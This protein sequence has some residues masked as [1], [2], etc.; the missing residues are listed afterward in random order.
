MAIQYDRLQ[1]KMIITGSDIQNLPAMLSKLRRVTA[2]FSLRLETET[3]THSTR[4]NYSA[5]NEEDRITWDDRAIYYYCVG[6]EHSPVKKFCLLA[7][8]H[9]VTVYYN[10]IHV[11]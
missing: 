9:T 3:T 2:E 4:N 10:P 6:V 5:T 8:L 7:E 11:R 1:G